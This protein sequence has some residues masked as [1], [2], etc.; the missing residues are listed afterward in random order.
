[1]NEIF[2]LPTQSSEAGI[3][4]TLPEKCTTIL[5]REKPVPAE[6]QLTR[7]EKFAKAKGITKQK[8]T[9]MVYDE[10]SG[11]YRPRWG[12]KAVTEGVEKDWLIEIPNS[13]GFASALCFNS[14][15]NG[16]SLC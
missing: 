11:E 7:W 3:L 2:S 10:Q 5:P 16:G 12:Y 9:R 4:A 14:R 15:S 13:A 6:K 8:R 1:M